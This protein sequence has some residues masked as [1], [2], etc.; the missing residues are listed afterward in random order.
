MQIKH[1]F[2]FTLILGLAWAGYL[3]GYITG[4][5]PGVN[6]IFG[7]NCNQSGCHVGNPVNATGGSL[8]LSGLPAQWTPGQAY[9][10]TV[11]VQRSGAV[12]YGF[13]L[14]AVVDATNQQAGSFT[15]GSSRVKVI[16]GGGV[17]YAEHSNAQVQPGPTFTV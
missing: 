2:L 7:P 13:Q 10:L 12:L 1:T 5:D 14:S 8:T 17:Q 11:T 3:F 15:P 4:P 6:G 16:T 9:P